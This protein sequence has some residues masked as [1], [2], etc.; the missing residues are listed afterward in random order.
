MRPQS[1]SKALGISRLSCRVLVY[2][3]LVGLSCLFCLPFLWALS[4]SLKSL[5]Q[6]F[7]PG[8]W[9]PWPIRWD[10]YVRVFDHIPFHLFFLNSLLVTGAC[11]VGQLSTAS[12]V[13]FSFARLRWW[14]GMSALSFS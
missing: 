9:F 1:G 5:D 13:A 14:A 4:A 7:A 2:G 10:N 6:V 12:L 8:H 11:L 3:T